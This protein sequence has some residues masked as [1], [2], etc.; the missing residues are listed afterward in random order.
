MQNFSDS[1]LINCHSDKAFKALTINISEWWGQ[2]DVLIKDRGDRF[3]VSWG[4][5]WYLFEVTHLKP[6]SSISWKCIDANQIIPGLAGVQKEWVGSEIQWSIESISEQQCRVHVVHEGLNEALICYDFCSSTWE[7][8][9]HQE[10][11]A[12]LE[13]GLES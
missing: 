9:I 4:D 5:P 2:Q 12:Y 7:R 8:F 6:G 13:S 1:I 3:R 11:K 10:L